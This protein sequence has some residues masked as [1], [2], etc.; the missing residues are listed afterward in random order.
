MQTPS[1]I[2]TDEVLQTNDGA[3]IAR[4]QTN[5]ELAAQAI[6]PSSNY[7]MNVR[8]RTTRKVNNENTPAE[9]FNVR[10]STATRNNQPAPHIQRLDE[11]R[12]IEQWK[13]NQLHI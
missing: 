1:R 3:N 10:E 12:S 11:H 5:L 13:N 9:Q 6:S 8:N 2:H 4:Q 7:V